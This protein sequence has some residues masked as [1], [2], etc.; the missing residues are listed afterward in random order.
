MH[1][2]L[3]E[4][5]ERRQGGRGR[6][7]MRYIYGTDQIER[8]GQGG[9][10]SF[11]PSVVDWVQALGVSFINDVKSPRWESKMTMQLGDGKKNT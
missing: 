10:F 3:S 2:C 8:S 9:C 1:E 6:G 4:G 5:G 7:M 11:F